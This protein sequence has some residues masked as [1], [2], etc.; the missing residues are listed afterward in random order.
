MKTSIM[1]AACDLCGREE[2]TREDC[3]FLK[4]PDGWYTLMVVREGKTVQGLLRPYTESDG[5]ED[6]MLDICPACY[7]TK[8]KAFIQSL[9]SEKVTA[10]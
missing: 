10:R 3:V 8:I 4:P 1:I 5:K 9:V 7:V 6:I 2:E